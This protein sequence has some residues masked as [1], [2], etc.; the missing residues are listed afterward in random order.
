MTKLNFQDGMSRLLFIKGENF[1]M[2]NRVCESTG[3]AHEVQCNN[4]CFEG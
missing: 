1:C 2:N 3:M 4:V